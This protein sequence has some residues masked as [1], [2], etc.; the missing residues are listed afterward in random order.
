[1]IIRVE[2]LT[3]LGPIQ[4][5]FCSQTTMCAEDKEEVITSPLRSITFNPLE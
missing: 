5:L 3:N 4:T 1:M 2:I